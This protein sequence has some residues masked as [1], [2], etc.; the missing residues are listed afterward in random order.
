MGKLSAWLGRRNDLRKLRVCLPT[1]LMS[2]PFRLHGSLHSCICAFA[3]YTYTDTYSHTRVRTRSHAAVPIPA[4]DF[5]CDIFS[6]QCGPGVE[7]C[8]SKLFC[9]AAVSCVTFG[10]ADEDV[11]LPPV[12]DDATLPQRLLIFIPGADVATSYYTATAQAIQQATTGLRL[13]VVIPTVTDQLCISQCPSSS[14]SVRHS[15]AGWQMRCP[16]PP[17]AARTSDWTPSLLAT[18]WAL[19]VQ[20][21]S[22]MVTTLT[23]PA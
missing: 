3:P 11:I 18:R 2:A 9:L 8:V 6:R 13:H 22:F 15:T 21:T 12:Y 17:S 20:T 10:N 5:V 23:T 14:L 16:S 4:Q 19:S 7:M 1:K